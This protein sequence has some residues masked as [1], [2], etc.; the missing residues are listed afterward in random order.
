MLSIFIFIF[1]LI[2]GSFLN[3]CIWRLP[4]N[5]SIIKPSSFCPK[6]GIPI[7]WYDNIPVLSYIILRGRCRFCKERIS[8]R[9]PLVELITAGLFLSLYLK[10]GVTFEF[11]KFV[12]LFSILVVVSFIDIDYHAIPGYLCLLGIIVGIIF[13]F[14][15]SYFY[16][17]EGGFLLNIPLIASLK[18]L[19]YGFGFTYLFKFLGDFFIEIYLAFKKKESIEGERESLGLGDV[20]FMGMIGLFM[21]IKAA[22]ITFFLAPFLAIIYCLYALIFKKSHLLPY[23]PYLS[24]AAIIV[25]FWQDK[26][27]SLVFRF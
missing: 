21:G 13:S 1:G 12:F 7:K 3:V 5:K 17:K 24:A 27:L 6:C 25:F 26:F 14:A 2:V 10:F 19:I 4:L 22:V 18:G 9:Y 16:L 8:F 15:Q 23:L 20:D 11:F